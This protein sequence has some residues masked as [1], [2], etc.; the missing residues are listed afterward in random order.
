MPNLKA[1]RLCLHFIAGF[2]ASVQKE[3]QELKM[4]E[5]EKI[6]EGLVLFGQETTEL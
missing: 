3:G 6:F 5:N 2:F 4:E 1:I